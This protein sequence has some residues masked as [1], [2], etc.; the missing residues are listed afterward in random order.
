M[1]FTCRRAGY[2]EKKQAALWWIGAQPAF[3][4]LCMVSD[5]AV[6]VVL[7]THSL[8]DHIRMVLGGLM[9][10]ELGKGFSFLPVF[11]GRLGLGPLRERRLMTP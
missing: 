3:L 5:I 10:A 2:E 1:L 9:A 4:C 8:R 6:G 11:L 7:A